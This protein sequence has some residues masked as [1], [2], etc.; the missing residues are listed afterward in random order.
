AK[1]DVKELDLRAA[2]L[3]S[4]YKKYGHLKAN[5]DPLG[6][7]LSQNV[8]ELHPKFHGIEESD[9]SK[10]VDIGNNT[11]ITIS[12]LI[13]KLNNLYSGN[14]GSEFEYIRCAEEREW[15]AS[16]IETTLSANLSKEEKTK[17]LKEVVRT[18]RFEQFLHK[19]FP[20]AKRFS[21]EG[22]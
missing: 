11:K 7:T 20:G 13:Q 6:L 17:I 4:A 16:E 10:T 14:I 15:L 2:N 1:I 5:L 18:T 12:D 22:G 8:P 19:R 9:L 21:I 3:I